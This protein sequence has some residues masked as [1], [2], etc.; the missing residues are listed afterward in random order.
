M[1]FK[2]QISWY[3]FYVK[4]FEKKTWYQ[5]NRSQVLLLTIIHITHVDLT[6]GSVKFFITKEPEAPIVSVCFMVI[7]HNWT[8]ISLLTAST[9]RFIHLHCELAQL[10]SFYCI[11]RIF[12]MSHPN[13]IAWNYWWCIKETRDLE[14]CCKKDTRAYT[15]N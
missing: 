9:K 6:Q 10:S 5:V 14:I 8:I 2:I 3:F 12:E 15:P 11:V 4:D 13:G 7:L 1:N